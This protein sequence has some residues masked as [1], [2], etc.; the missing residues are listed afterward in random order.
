MQRSNRLSKTF[1]ERVRRPGRYGEGRGSRGLALLV[2]PAADGGITKSWVQRLIIDGKPTNLGLGPAPGITLDRARELALHNWRLVF[3]DGIDPRRKE[4][5]A[6]PTFKVAAEAKIKIEA[7]RWKGK[8]EKLW[9]SRLGTH[10][11]PA[12]GAKSVDRITTA[13]V[14]AV[15]LPI[16]EASHTTAVKVRSYLRAVMGW[17]VSKGHRTD[18]PAG[19]GINEA[20]PKANGK[21]QHHKALGHADVAEALSTV[22]ASGAWWATVEC[23]KM[24]VLTAARS[25]EIRGARWTE[26]DREGRVWTIPALRMKSGREHRVPLSDAAMAVLDRAAALSDGT[27]LIFPSVRGLELADSTVSKLLR[28]AGIEAVPHGF[29]SSFRDWAAENNIPR[30]LAEASLAHAVESATEAA[31]L[32]SDVLERRRDVMQRW[33]DYLA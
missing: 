14:L 30:E 7:P 25:G 9:H 15:L 28:D 18:N 22:E 31:Y 4:G 33:A 23:F 12:I 13:D 1:V 26:I 2:K 16:Y 29:R 5:A 19:D 27:G 6:V 17:A 21:T 11:Y 20:L 24:L 3:V 10:V 8:T 32:R